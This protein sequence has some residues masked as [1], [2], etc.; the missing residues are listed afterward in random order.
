MKKIFVLVCAAFLS[1]CTIHA[2]EHIFW[3]E[4][5]NWFFEKGS[6]AIDFFSQEPKLLKTEYITEDSRKKGLVS[7]A[8]A[9]KS[10]LAQKTYEKRY[11]IKDEVQAVKKGTLVREGL[12]LNFQK[13]EKVSLIGQV[14][15]DGEDFV[16][17]TITKCFIVRISWVFGV[18]GNNFIK[19]MLKLAKL[20]KTELNVVSDQ[21]GSPTYTA[22]LAVLLCDMIASNKYGIYHATNEGIC[23]W[24]EFA[25]KIF[26]L[27]N[28][29]IKVNSI[30]T[31]EYCKLVPNQAV[32]PLNSRLSKKSLD[33]AGFNRLPNWEDALER[34]LKELSI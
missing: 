25:K 22:D 32:R 27:S 16:L 9:G 8:Y 18:N 10:M 34:Y 11:M 30:T 23:S 6:Y 21:V 13:G 12:S 5:D 3:K 28:I 19:T 4:R 31:E 2:G 20:G 15:I 29:N 1:S 33:R 14:Q 24:C 17:N 26:E 7:S